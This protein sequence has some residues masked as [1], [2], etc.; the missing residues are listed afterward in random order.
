MSNQQE[1][2]VPEVLYRDD[3]HKFSVYRLCDIPDGVPRSGRR[4]VGDDV[5]SFWRNRAIAVGAD[6]R[7]RFARYSRRAE[8]RD[9]ADRAAVCCAVLDEHAGPLLAAPK[10]TLKVKSY[11]IE[12]PAAEFHAEMTKHDGARH[13]EQSV[14]YTPHRN[15]PNVLRA[16]ERWSAHLRFLVK[17]SEQRDRDHRPSV[18]VQLDD[19]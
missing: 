6:I 8:F 4:A 16:S 3:V 2:T 11:V 7:K 14:Y 10:L 13:G 1:R 19:D 17:Q 9:V 15:N 12:I 18:L 5:A